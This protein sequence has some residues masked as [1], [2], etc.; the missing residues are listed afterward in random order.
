[1]SEVRLVGTGG[2][3]ERDLFLAVVDDLGIWA[4]DLSS[5]RA[6]FIVVTALD[7]RSVD[8]Q[9]LLSFAERLVAAGCRYSCSFGPTTSACIRRSTTPPYEPD[10]MT[11]TNRGTS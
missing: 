11:M 2:S 9:I 3:F 1:L 4:P 8:D 10:W 7:T 5:V 6:P